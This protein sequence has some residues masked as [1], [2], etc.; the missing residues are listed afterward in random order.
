[1]WVRTSALQIAP[2]GT[3][4]FRSVDNSGSDKC[5]TPSSVA[6]RIGSC[7]ATLAQTFDRASLNRHIPA[8]DQPS[9]FPRVP[10]VHHDGGIQ[11]GDDEGLMAESALGQVST[12]VGM[13]RVVACNGSANQSSRRSP[14]EAVDAWKP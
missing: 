14:A 7:K 4:S 5:P 8:L 3:G 6:G 9:V 10:S 11:Q 12:P 13:W 2:K 1:M